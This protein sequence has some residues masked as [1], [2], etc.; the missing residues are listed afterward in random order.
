MPPPLY[1][2]RAAA[3]RHNRPIIELNVQLLLS[4]PGRAPAVA[5][6][7]FWNLGPY[8]ATDHVHFSGL[9]ILREEQKKVLF[10]SYSKWF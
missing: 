5:C 7:T 2:Q 8:G 3:A 6:R 9:V 1:T 10:T 4:E